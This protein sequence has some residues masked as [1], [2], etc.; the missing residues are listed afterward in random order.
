MQSS[1][2]IFV[3]DLDKV[4]KYLDSIMFADDTNLFYPHKIIKTLFQIINSEFKLAN[5]WFH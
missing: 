2:L 5:E 4:T 1:S 3:N